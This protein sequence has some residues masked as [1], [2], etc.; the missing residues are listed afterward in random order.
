MGSGQG[1][2]RLR[3]GRR[4]PARTATG[5]VPEAPFVPRRGRK[6]GPHGGARRGIGNP[7][8]NARPV[9][10]P[11]PTP[12]RTRRHG[13]R[14]GSVMAAPP[15]GSDPVTARMSGIV[16]RSIGR[17]VPTPQ[18]RRRRIG[19]W[20]TRRDPRAARAA[21]GPPMAHPG[22]TGRVGHPPASRPTAPRAPMER[23][24]GPPAALPSSAAVSC[25][26]SY[27]FVSPRTSAAPF[28]TALWSAMTREW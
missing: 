10:A 9:H 14:S 24:A 25:G 18:C 5:A 19:S 4:R 13:C 17:D 6:T 3:P 28:T 21:V 20:P 8:R 7:H 15:H 23:A 22:Q 12:R 16:R 2:L 11:S 27:S 1:H 26:R